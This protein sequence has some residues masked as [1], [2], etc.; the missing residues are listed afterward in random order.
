MIGGN[1]LVPGYPPL[2]KLAFFLDGALGGASVHR[3]QYTWPRLLKK[4]DDVFCVV[5]PIN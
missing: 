5:Q 3:E 4:T 2:W 1:S